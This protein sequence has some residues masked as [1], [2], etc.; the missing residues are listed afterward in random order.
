MVMVVDLRP[1]SRDGRGA[2]AAQLSLVPSHTGT[3]PLSAAD[4]VVVG[5][6]WL[7]TAH[8]IDEVRYI[9]VLYGC[10]SGREE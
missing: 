3:L 4:L 2:V 5:M 7:L 6:P 10:E 8:E 9:K 1:V